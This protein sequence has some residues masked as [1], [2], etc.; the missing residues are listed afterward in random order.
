MNRLEHAPS[1]GGDRYHKIGCDR[2]A[3]QDVFVDVFLDAHGK[4]PRDNG[5]TIMVAVE[6]QSG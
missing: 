4:T 6:R 1:D 5:A 2:E 3:L